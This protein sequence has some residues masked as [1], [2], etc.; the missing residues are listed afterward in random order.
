[1]PDPYRILNLPRDADAAAIKAAYRRLAKSLHP[2]RNPGDPE[3]ERR[4]KDLT[5]A[6]HLLSDPQTRARFDRGEIDADG[7]PRSP[8]GFAGRGG[9]APHRAF[10]TS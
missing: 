9:F 3:A 2:D 10:F 4:F 8:F 5:R 1:M 6:Y 7:R